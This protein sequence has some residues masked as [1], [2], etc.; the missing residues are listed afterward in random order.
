MRVFYFDLVKISR[1]FLVFFLLTT[2]AI[3]FSMIVRQNVPSTAGAA[4]SVITKVQT[5]EK[6]AALTFD[7]TLETDVATIVRSLEE[8]QITAT[9]FL[10]PDWAQNN[11]KA[12]RHMALK[13]HEI[14]VLLDSKV[15]INNYPENMDKAKELYSLWAG[16]SPRLVRL[17]DNKPDAKGPQI[18]HSHGFKVIDST[19]KIQ[20][21]PGQNTDWLLPGSILHIIPQ[22]SSS[23]TQ[24]LLTEVMS[25]AKEEH[26]R[27]NTLS[28]LLSYGPGIVN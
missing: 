3:L 14:G 15:I 18:L 13:G 8:N 4:G 24:K 26:F 1:N 25:A 27:L 7:I 6:V 12:I 2:T 20:D 16:S 23:T 21:M 11:Q 17:T 9:F 5:Q 10:D 19:V 28:E 22:S